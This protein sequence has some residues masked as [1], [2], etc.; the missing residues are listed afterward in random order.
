MSKKDQGRARSFALISYQ[1][2]ETIKAVLKAN[3]SRIRNFA[4]ILH[5]KDTHDDGSPQEVHF[6]I[7]LDM[8]NPMSLSA[9]RRLFPQGDGVPNTLGQVMR[10]KC[11]CFNYL[12]HANLE[13]KFHYSHDGIR[14]NDIEYWERCIDSGDTDDKCIKI[15]EDIIARVPLFIMLQRY[16]REFVIYRDKYVSYAADMKREEETPVDGV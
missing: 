6:H 5:D 2:E 4:Y 16:G 14:S 9:C 10:D 3:N 7:L 12:D 8:Y 11:D 1:D 13:G 15:C